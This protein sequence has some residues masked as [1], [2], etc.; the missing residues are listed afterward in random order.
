MAMKVMQINSYFHY[1]STGKIEK[2]IN[3][4]LVS[5]GVE[6]Y[7]CYSVDTSFDKRKETT[8]LKYGTRLEKFITAGLM[9]IT[10]N[11]YG[12]ACFSTQTL[13][14]HIRRAK[15]DVVHIHCPNSYDV[16]LHSL[17]RYLKKHQYKTVITEHA[18]FFHTGNCPYALDCDR[19][20]SGCYRCPRRYYATKSKL[21]DATRKNWHRMK[22]TFDGFTT[23]TLSPVSPW[24]G[25][26]TVVSGITKDIPCKVVLNG[27]N[28]ECFRHY[29]KEEIGRDIQSAFTQK[30]V[31]F[32]TSD[33]YSDVKGGKYVLELAK[34]LPEYRFLI[35]CS[36]DVD[37]LGLENV[38]H[39]NF[40]KNQYD[41]A[42][43][44]SLADVTVLAS[45]KETFSMPVA[46]S[47]CCGT[48]VV[49]FK[50][51]GPESIALSQYCDFVEYGD[52]DALKEA[53]VNMVEN[54]SEDKQVV[55]ESAIKRYSSQ[56]MAAEYFKL[57]KEI[58][59][60]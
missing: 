48:P 59:R 10:G 60:Q 7:I 42:K 54:F 49:G 50:A 18:E 53:L 37:C 28:T 32:I 40:I 30:T 31:L 21:F 1:G 39:L 33:F 41:L 14:R 19:W 47:L 25:E 43:Y 17:L 22:K 38:T 34:R 55:S 44:Y 11:R 46:E 12:Y 20:V 13:K 35:I 2:D 4:Y 29:T 6:T 9:R 27:I 24:L 36:A 8:F 23:A 51:G 57:Y 5:Q 45:K 52:L 3:D 26:R 15:P 58:Y 16:N 56:T